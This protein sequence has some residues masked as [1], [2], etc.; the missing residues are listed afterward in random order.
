MSRIFL[1]HANNDREFVE[2]E[3]LGLLK[4]LGFEPWFAEEDIRTSE[5]WEQSILRGLRRSDWFLL[6]MSPSAAKSEWVKRELSWAMSERVGRII[7]ILIEDCEPVDFHIGL[8]RI[9]HADFRADRKVARETL[10]KLMVD[11]EYSPLRR[12]RTIA[13]EWKGAIHQDKGPKGQA[14]EYR[15][16][17]TLDV[18]RNMITGEFAYSVSLEDSAIEARMIASGKSFYDRFIQLNY[19]PKDPGAIHFGTM[20]LEVSAKGNTASGY[21]TGYGATSEG[22]ITGRVTLHKT[23]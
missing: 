8:P 7:P 18:Y 21:F 1:S 10:I 20:I 22:L 11:E 5:H 12:L 16:T 13:G 9:Q 3:L 4:A 15:L 14:I 2:E 17:G 23:V 6:V 19:E